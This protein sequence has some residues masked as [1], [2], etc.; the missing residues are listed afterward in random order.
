MGGVTDFY[1][2]EMSLFG[3]QMLENVSVC[4]VVLQTVVAV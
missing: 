1:P 3:K 4:K 2:L